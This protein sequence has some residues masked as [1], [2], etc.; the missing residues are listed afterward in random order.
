MELIRAFELFG[1]LVG[2][3][4]VD[5]EREEAGRVVQLAVYRI[6]RSLS[7]SER[8]IE[9]AE[10][11]VLCALL[12]RGPEG[13]TR[14]PPQTDEEVRRVLYRALRNAAIDAWR[15][16]ERS[17]PEVELDEHAAELLVAKDT[18][19]FEEAALARCRQELNEAS[20]ELEHAVFPALAAGMKGGGAVLLDTL[21]ALRQIVTGEETQDSVIDAIARG[22]DLRSADDRFR[23]RVSAA[24]ERVL[25]WLDDP[26]ER[27]AHHPH[28]WLA[29]EILIEELFDPGRGR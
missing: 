21:R 25:A 18:D 12:R 15:T 22:G 17:R 27:A 9:A 1:P 29:F 2:D 24:R 11:H 10:F 5:A 28:W 6:S 26:V 23:K 16:G 13:M 7:S 4:A 14:R 19:A 3:P 8:F 20:A